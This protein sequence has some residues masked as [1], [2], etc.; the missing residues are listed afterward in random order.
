[1]SSAQIWHNCFCLRNNFKPP[2]I[3]TGQGNVQTCP[4]HTGDVHT[5][6]EREPDPNSGRVTVGKPLTLSEPEQRHL[7]DDNETTQTLQGFIGLTHANL[8]NGAQQSSRRGTVVNESDE[9]P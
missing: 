8:R 7:C 3:S 2:H 6:V 1:M 5:A 4:L 9:E